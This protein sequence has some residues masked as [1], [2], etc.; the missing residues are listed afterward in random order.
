MDY[1]KKIEQDIAEKYKKILLEKLPP[2]SIIPAHTADGHFY[3]V[4]KSVRTFPSVTG[5]LQVIKDPSLMNWKMNCALDYIWNSCQEKMPQDIC[6]IQILLANAKNEPQK[7]FE[8]AGNIGKVTHDRRQSYYQ[9]WINTGV[10]P[11]VKDYM[12]EEDDPRLWSGMRA[13]SK[14]C[15]DTGYIPVATELLL[16]SDKLG[17]AGTLDDLGIIDGK[18]VLCD[19]K[20]SNQAKDQYW[21]Q[22]AMYYQMLIERTGLKP[23]ECFVLKTSKENGTYVLEYLK[24]IRKLVSYAK[25]IIKVDEGINFVKGKRIKET[26]KL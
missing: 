11:D 7:D 24:D 17:L 6:D 14:F 20:T 18:L 21:F 8:D 22:I 1:I 12:K 4:E 5:A 23:R 15:D 19:L 3:Y 9:D 2:G 26:I 10:R 25:A 16:W 13:I